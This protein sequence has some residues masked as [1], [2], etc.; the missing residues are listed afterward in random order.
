MK[1]EF[2]VFLKIE[3]QKKLERAKIILDKDYDNYYAYYLLSNYRR[4][5][6]YKDKTINNPFK[7]SY[8]LTGYAPEDKFKTN[9]E[10]FFRKKDLTR[11]LLQSFSYKLRVGAAWPDVEKIIFIKNKKIKFEEINL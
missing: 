8:Q 4:G 1:R 3:N 11:N 7:Y 9:M 2:D 6:G 10:T 5:V